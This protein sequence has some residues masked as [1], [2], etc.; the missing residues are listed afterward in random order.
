MLGAVKDV[1]FAGNGSGRDQIAVL[2]TVP[3]AVD[4]AIMVDLLHDRESS[5]GGRIAADLSLVLVVLLEV[6]PG[7]GRIG[8]AIGA[9]GG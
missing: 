2:R 3:C 4:L 9:G 5:G 7:F 8:W 6:E 1:G